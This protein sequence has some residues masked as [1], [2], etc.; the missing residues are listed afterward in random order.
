M[1]EPENRHKWL[2]SVTIIDLSDSLAGRYASRLLKD[3]GGTVQRCSSIPARVDVAVT[4]GSD[5]AL[6]ALLAILQ[7][8]DTVADEATTCGAL[9]QADIVLCSASSWSSFGLEQAAHDHPSISIVAISDVGL[10][11]PLAGARLDS[12][13]RQALTGS[14]YWRGDPEQPPL[15]AGGEIEHFLAG[16]YAAAAAVA[17]LRRSRRTGAGETFDLSLL[18]VCNAGLTTFGATLASLWGRL[19][20]DFPAGPSKSRRSN[21]PRMVGS[22]SV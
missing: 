13:L 6:E 1:N 2:S 18:E 17:G 15:I 7:N 22:A 21:G 19:G 20:E 5:A 8:G 3:A 10:D 11:G 12:C 4:G 16:A 14:L 9:P